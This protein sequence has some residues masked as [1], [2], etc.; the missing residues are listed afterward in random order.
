MEDK[1][2]GVGRERIREQESDSE[3]GREIVGVE[4]RDWE[5]NLMAHAAVRER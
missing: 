5:P 1:E 4:E 2:R 3:R